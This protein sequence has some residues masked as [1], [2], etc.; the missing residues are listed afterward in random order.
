M[1]RESDVPAL[2]FWSRFLYQLLQSR[3]LI[4]RDSLLL[5]IGCR[6]LRSSRALT[7]VFDE[8]YRGVD[9][10]PE[11]VAA[12]RRWLPSR[13][14]YGEIRAT[15]PT[16]FG[17][18]FG[19]KFDVILASSVVFHLTDELAAEWFKSLS[20]LLVPGGAAI[21][22]INEREAE[23][24]WEGL[25]FVRRPLAFYEG[26]AAEYGLAVEALG[27]SLDLGCEPDP[28][29]PESGFNTILEIRRAY[30]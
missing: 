14:L 12:G 5:E 2:T 22:N 7:I 21:C 19:C 28:E 11:C 30:V 16:D 23:A 25:P 1:F 24:A 10:N 27:T 4:A 9:I 20:E 8:R 29:H 6:D 15:E 3:S 13:G 18:C 26:L 17:R